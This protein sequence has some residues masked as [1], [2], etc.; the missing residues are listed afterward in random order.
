MGLVLDPGGDI[1]NMPTPS[2]D[3]IDSRD[4][5]DAISD[6]IESG[7]NPD[8]LAMLQGLAA[9]AADYSEG[10]EYGVPLVRDSY[11]IHHA[12]EFAEDCG[13]FNVSRN[14]AARWPYN[15]IDW[16]KA[17]RELQWDYTAVRFNGVTYWVR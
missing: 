1:M 4:I 2:D 5:I 11:F 10:W 13:M 7:A 3:I 9:E 6:L 12:M 15:C 16:E 17:A 8:L 14:S